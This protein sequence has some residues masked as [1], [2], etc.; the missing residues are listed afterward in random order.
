[1]R[2]PE[3]R[4][5]R[6]P[7]GPRQ[8]T[9]S[10]QK[11]GLPPVRSRPTAPLPRSRPGRHSLWCSFFLILLA[12]Q[13]ARAT[14]HEPLAP[15]RCRDGAGLGVHDILRRRRLPRPQNPAG[16]AWRLVNV[17]PKSH[18]SSRPIALRTRFP[19]LEGFSPPEGLSPS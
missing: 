7:W 13:C 2:S 1:M 4:P 5:L 18:A 16:S 17:Q 19:P 11:D 9:G 15:P 14:H 3:T 10:R 8:Q 6:S 12:L